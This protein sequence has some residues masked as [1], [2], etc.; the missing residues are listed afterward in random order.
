[1]DEG[2]R[3]AVDIEGF[4]T[5]AN[6]RRT[7]PCRVLWK[8]LQIGR[9]KVLWTTIDRLLAR[10][11]SCQCLQLA[12]LPFNVSSARYMPGR[13]FEGC[14]HQRAQCRLLKN[15]GF[16]LR[17]TSRMALTSQTPAHRKG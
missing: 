3:P 6:E 13:Y 14:D 16:L 11:S 1:M 9:K 17:D 8:A 4:L 7:Y 5:C 10:N 2:A 12:A 15:L